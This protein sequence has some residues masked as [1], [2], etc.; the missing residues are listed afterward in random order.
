MITHDLA[1]AFHVGVRVH[2]LDAAMVELSDANGLTWCEVQERQQP[3]W[4]PELGAV[5]TPLRF[6]YSTAGPLHIELLQGERG[7]IWD[8]H[9]GTGLHH[10][11]VWSG[12]VR[13]ETLAMMEQG[14][15]LV[16][17]QS[18]PEDGFGVMSYVQS[19]AGFILELVDA[20]ALPRFESWWAGGS[21]G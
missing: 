1:N 5:V 21:L 20:R 3:L 14:W 2:D 4:M 15:T 18:S 7:T 17:A 6:T 11:G 9:A 13:G 12:D 8:A 16:G 19:P 10:T